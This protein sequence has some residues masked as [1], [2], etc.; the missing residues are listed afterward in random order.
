MTVVDELGV[1]PYDT[2]NVEMWQPLTRK[3]APHITVCWEIDARRW[4]DLLYKTLQA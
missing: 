2:A 3:G 4:K 1:T